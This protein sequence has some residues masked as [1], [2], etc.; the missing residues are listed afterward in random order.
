MFK[1]T[2]LPNGLRLITAPM[3]GSQSTTV[4]VFFAAGSKYESKENN[5]ISHFLEH[6]FFK[7]TKK[8]PT[9]LALSEYLDRVGGEFNAFTS[10]EMTGYYAKVAPEY[11]DMALDWVSDILLNSKFDA[12]EIDKERGVITEEINMSLD[13]P[14]RYLGDL[15]EE[16]LYGDQPA[17]WQ[18]IGTKENISKMARTQFVDYF[19]THYRTKNAVVCLAG[20]IDKDMEKKVL[21]YF[22]GLKKGEGQTKSAVREAQSKPE[23]MVYHKATDQT[24]LRL[25]VRA[26]DMFHKD[27]YA[28][29]VLAAIL[30]GMMSSRLFISVR[31]KRGLA[32]YVRSAAENYTD[33]G[34]FVTQAG[35][36][37]EKAEEAIEAILTEYKK[38]RDIK[39][40]AAEIKKAKEWLQGSLRLGLET[41]DEMASWVGLQEL[42]RKGVLTPEQIFSKIKAVSQSD[43]A[44]VA[45]DIFR[46]EKLNLALIG[47]FKEKEKFEKFLKI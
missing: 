25:G 10:Q 45:K 19:N 47:P 36:A 43:L 34:Y 7:G 44:R 32:Y 6:M 8:R 31:E 22:G 39:V 24:H 5:G 9:T 13:N 17:G 3:A 28:L 42:L 38:I 26:Y 35:V 46:P 4:L 18:I 16:L 37:N 15:W 2:I 11:A 14:M 41:S 40:G 30:G 29:M 1:K 20:K 33:C 21:K 23:V 12:K 27:R